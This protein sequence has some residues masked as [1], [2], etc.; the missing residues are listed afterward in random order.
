MAF[1]DDTDASD[2]DDEE[3]FNVEEDEEADDD[4]GDD[5]EYAH[6]ASW[7][8]KKSAYYSGNK[9]ENADDAELEEEEARALQNKMMKQLDSNDFG[10]DA[11]SLKQQQQNNNNNNN[12]NMNNNNQAAIKSGQELVA[13][14]LASKAFVLDDQKLEKI[15]KNL[16]KMSKREKLDLLKQE[17]PEMFELVREF[18]E[19]IEELQSILL[20]LSEAHRSGIVPSSLAAEYVVNKTK[21]YLMYAAYLSFYFVLKAQRVAVDNHPVVKNILQFRYVS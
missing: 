4:D 15:A 8:S 21:L 7:G 5:D 10:L 3:D 11:F 1:G 18:R 13:I 17:S 14:R 12:N 19:K 2:D 16:S 20:P 6:G 9:I